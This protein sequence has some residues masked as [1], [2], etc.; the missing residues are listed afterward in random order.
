MEIQS[1]KSDGLTEIVGTARPLLAARPCLPARSLRNRW[2]PI[3]RRPPL[4]S[5][6]HPAASLPLHSQTAYGNALPGLFPPPVAG[7][8]QSQLFALGVARGY[9]NSILEINS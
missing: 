5:G 7:S 8:P 6:G 9:V 3:R 1:N 2:A 4:K